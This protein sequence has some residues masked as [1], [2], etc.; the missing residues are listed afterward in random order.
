MAHTKSAKKR[1]RQNQERRLRNRSHRSRLRTQVKGLREAISA[2]DEE[3]TQQELPRTAALLD[4][5]A[6]R[7]ILHRNAAARAKSRLTRAAN[8]LFGKEEPAP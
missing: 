3:R 6:G 8:A 5:M 7:G 4:R 1:V 2:G